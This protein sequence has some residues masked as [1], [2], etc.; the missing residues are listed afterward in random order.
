MKTQKTSSN[1]HLSKEVHV[2]EKGEP[3]MQHQKHSQRDNGASGVVEARVERV[4]DVAHKKGS[5][6]SV[7]TP[8]KQPAKKARRDYAE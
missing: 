8:N 6:N 1:V 3:S 5:R 4:T 2:E 7:G